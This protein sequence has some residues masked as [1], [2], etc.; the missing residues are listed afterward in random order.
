MAPVSALFAN[1]PLACAWSP[2]WMPLGAQAAKDSWLT[3][4]WVQD[5]R[6]MATGDGMSIPAYEAQARAAASRP[7]RGAAGRLAHG[8][9]ALIRGRT[10]VHPPVKAPPSTGLGASAFRLPRHR[11]VLEHEPRAGHGHGP[12]AGCGWLDVFGREGSW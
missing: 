8:T 2:L 1:L 11:P 7:H 12:V 3:R 4:R 10:D 9:P 6:F 5:H